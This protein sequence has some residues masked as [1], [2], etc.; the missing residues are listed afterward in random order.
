M[1]HSIENNEDMIESIYT[2]EHGQLTLN[3][4]QDNIPVLTI[5]NEKGFFP[6]SSASAAVYAKANANANSCYET[7]TP[8][9]SLITNAK[10]YQIVATSQDKNEYRR[11][12]KI[13]QDMKHKNGGIP[14]GTDNNDNTNNTDRDL[15]LLGEG[16]FTLYDPVD[17]TP[18]EVVFIA[19]CGNIQFYL[20]KDD[21][22]I[23]IS[24]S[25]YVFMMPNDCLILSFND[26]NENTKLTSTQR[27]LPSIKALLAARTKF[28]DE[29]ETIEN[30]K[31]RKSLISSSS[32]SNHH[33]NDNKSDKVSKHVHSASI[34]ISN[35]IVKAG[36]YGSR[37]IEAYGE[38]KR[39]R[40]LLVEEES[41][42]SGSKEIIHIPKISIKAAK[43]ARSI[44]KTTGKA[45][46]KVSDKVSDMIGDQIA[47]HIMSSSSSSGSDSSSRMKRNG[48]RLLLSSSIAYAEISDGFDCAYD[49]ILQTLRME[50]TE[51]IEQKY[52]HDLS[53]LSRHTAGATIY[54]GKTLLTARR[55]INVN[56]MLKT[57]V[58]KAVVKNQKE[59]ML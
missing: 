48:K 12:A 4:T 31:F 57:G 50:S 5:S 44:T 11:K 58:E 40:L 39:E 1:S 51:Y 46:T 38:Q 22:T 37:R 27:N 9:H 49:T 19:N 43:V 34:W 10:L 14:T 45:V 15:P 52:G 53:E 8:L 36:N 29:S 16:T 20:M 59:R 26:D 33:S 24:S 42:G 28:H 3:T 47:K 35:K 17:G 2:N 21:V 32:S 13:T 6:T 41:S 18:E 23:K 56:K 54:F 25:E 30:A 55:I 7:P